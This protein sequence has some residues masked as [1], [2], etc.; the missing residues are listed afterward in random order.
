MR[1]GRG[2][3]RRESDEDTEI[4]VLVTAQADLDPDQDKSTSRLRC[5]RELVSDHGLREQLFLS[6]F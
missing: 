4:S 1:P 2:G 5:L 6:F 3:S